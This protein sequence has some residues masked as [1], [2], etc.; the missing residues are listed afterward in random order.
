[1]GCISYPSQIPSVLDQHVLKSASGSDERDVSLARFPND[2]NS[3][4]GF[5][6]RAAGANDDGRSRSGDAAGIVNGVGGRDAH[7][8]W[9]PQGVRRMSEGGESCLVIWVICRQ[10]YQHHDGD[11]AHR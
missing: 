8:D 1:M 10:I 5:A 9:D 7:L 3:R 6:V 2:F 4:V 11:G